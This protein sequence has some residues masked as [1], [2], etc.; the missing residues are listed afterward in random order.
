MKKLINILMLGAMLVSFTGCW[1]DEVIDAGAARPQVENLKAVPGDEE[2]VVT[3]TMPDGWNPTDF[4]ITYSTPESE[5]VSFRTGKLGEYTYTIGQLVNDYQYSF[6]IQAVYGELISGAVTAIAK[7]STSRFPVTDLSANGDNASV[8]LTWTRPSMLVTGYTLTYFQDPTPADVKTMDIAA[9]AETV[10]VTGLTNDISHTFSLVANYTRGASDPATVK[11]LPTLAI[12]YFVDK[13]ETAIGLPVHFSFNRADYTDAA[14]VTWTFPGNIVKKGDEVDYA[15]TSQGTQTVELSIL[16]GVNKRTWTIEI[17]VREY[18]LWYSEWVMDGTTFNGFKGSCP[19]FS[20]DGST[21][22]DITFSKITS[23][24]AFDVASGNLKWVFTPTAKSASYNMLTVNPVNGDI[25]FGT[26]SAGQF[27]CVSAEGEQRWM[28]TEAQSMQSAAPAVNATGTVVYL[29]DK[30]GNVFALDA[31][32]GTK[33]WGGSLGN[34]CTAIL[35][36]GNEVV[37][38]STDKGIFFLD[39]ETGAEIAKIT[40][41]TKISDITGFAVAADKRTV[42]VP[43]NSGCMSKIDIIDHKVI[44][45][46]KVNSNASPNTMYEPIVAPNGD[47]FVGSKDSY[48]YCFD[49]DLNE[50]WTYKVL[51]KANA[52][53]YS[54]PCVDTEGN[55]YITSGQELNHC[56][57]FS[58]TGA[59][60][61][62][63][64]FGSN[65]TAQKQMGG[66]NLLN[67]VLYSAFV[68]ASGENGLFV[69]IGVGYD[70]ASSWS[71]HG[72]DPCGSCCI[73]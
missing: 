40:L 64:S 68:G 12:P 21:V 22:Y 27:Y 48:V 19:V 50:K 72:G 11:A 8:T 28:F 32:T 67:G 4:I 37:M 51:D 73:K 33:K 14:D 2:A 16:S 43:Q 54:H 55:F 30:S 1:D 10:T 58:P 31:A 15:F 25:Y 52:F 41:S 26:T 3:W 47:V 61:L 9:D 5:K 24:Y 60:I 18:A 66:N 65:G 59:V 62:D 56:L 45:D 44:I 38:G 7:P 20:P 34:S 13:T 42:Y 49:S 57:G 39:S 35:V 53:N 46:S 71:T 70:R 69:G 17:Q 6:D 36:N 23:L 29:G 63:Q